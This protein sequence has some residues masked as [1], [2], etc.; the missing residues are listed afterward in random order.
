MEEVIS[1]LRKLHKRFVNE[2]ISSNSIRF[3]EIVLCRLYDR[4]HLSNEKLK[5]TIVSL[6]E[7]LS[8][9]LSLSPEEMDYIESLE[10][11]VGY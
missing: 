9:E 4:P 8:S 1:F 3:L 7:V 6:Q 5:D 2:G 11:L 10:D